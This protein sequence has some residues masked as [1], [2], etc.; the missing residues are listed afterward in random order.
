MKEEIP[1]E[2]ILKQLKENNKSLR[3]SR[4]PGNTK[5]RFIALADA[6]FEGDYGMTLKWLMDGLVSVETAEI[7]DQISELRTRIERLES[8]PKQDGKVVRKML[9]G[10]TKKVNS[11]E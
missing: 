9:S 1:T 11:N 5:P 4:V 6:D 8:I 10:N 3:M 2:K 7:L